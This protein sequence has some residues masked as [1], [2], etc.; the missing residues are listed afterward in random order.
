MKNIFSNNL[1]IL[2]KKSWTFCRS[3]KI[4]LSKLKLEDIP[5]NP[6]QLDSKN[7]ANLLKKF[8]LKDCNRLNPENYVSALVSRADLPQAL[9]PDNKFFKEPQ[10]FDPQHSLVCIHEKHRLEAAQQ[11]LAGDK[12]WWVLNLYSDGVTL[13]VW[14]LGL[15]LTVFKTSIFRVRMHYM[16]KTPVQQN[17]SME[18]SIAESVSQP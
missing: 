15:P 16:N 6:R 5:D 3:F 10:H 14:L 1:Q 2:Q 9:Q 17:T 8:N 4:P 12:Q 18:T 13:W 7:V 11:F